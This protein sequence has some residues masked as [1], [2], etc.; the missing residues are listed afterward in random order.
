MSS[1]HCSVLASRPRRLR[2]S[3]SN[4]LA[5]RHRGRR[6]GDVRLVFMLSTFMAL[7]CAL[8]EWTVSL[9]SRSLTLLRSYASVRGTM[10]SRPPIFL[11]ELHEALRAAARLEILEAQRGRLSY[12]SMRARSSSICAS[13]A[14]SRLL[15]AG[16]LLVPEL[17]EL[18]ALLV[19]R[20]LELALAACA[21][22]AR[23]SSWSL[24]ACAYV[25][26]RILI[27]PLGLFASMS[28]SAA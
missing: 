14:G 7:P 8:I 4:L 5:A 9:L 13:T 20:V 24:R 2:S 11:R 16:H 25:F 12:A 6:R 18:E 21:R 15:R 19:E 22:P 1:I 28:W 23:R 17:Q 26:T 27:E 10:P 3:S